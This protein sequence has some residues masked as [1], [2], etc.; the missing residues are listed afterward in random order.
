MSTQS[1]F[2]LFA[3]LSD[4]EYERLKTDIAKRGVLVPVELDERGEVLDG[5]HRIRACKELGITDYPRVVRT[6]LTG[7]AEKRSHVRALNLLRRHLSQEQRRAVI[8]EELKENPERSNRQIAASLGVDDKTVGAVRSDLQLSAEIPQIAERTVTR[9]GSTYQQKPKQSAAIIATT[10]A[11]EKKA[12]AA[13]PF[14][15]EGV[16]VSTATAQRAAQTAAR[17]IAE[18]AEAFLN[19]AIDRDGAIADA[20]LCRAYTDIAY[21]IRRD[22]LPLNA[23][24]LGEVLESDVWPEAEML[25]AD[26]EAWFRQLEAA[27]PSRLR[28]MEARR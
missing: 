1:R 19:S 11:E 4:D 12:V 21:L 25:R 27:R 18:D 13:A 28:L 3:P 17:S 23:D 24:R 14:A 6:N 26:V 2:Q 15:P 5:H 9:K 7:D 16:A 22:L 8:A 10:P 20:R